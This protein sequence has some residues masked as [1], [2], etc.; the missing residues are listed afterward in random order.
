M[1]GQVCPRAL[2]L[3][4]LAIEAWLYKMASLDA[5]SPIVG[6]FARVTLVDSREFPLH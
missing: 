2:L 5:A 1:V 3:G 4:A 6:E